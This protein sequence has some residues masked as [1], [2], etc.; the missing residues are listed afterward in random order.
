MEET[1]MMSMDDLMALVVEYYNIVINWLQT[2]LFTIESSTQLAIVG[3]L[4]LISYA[5]NRSLTPFLHKVFEEKPIYQ[6]IEKAAKEMYLPI[7][8]WLLVLI[9]LQVAE[10]L[11]MPII[12]LRLAWSLITL[13]IAINLITVMIESETISRIVRIVIWTG[14]ILNIFGLF[15]LNFCFS[16]VN[17]LF[18]MYE[19]HV[20]SIVTR[21]CNI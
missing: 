14:A 16:I 4:F 1:E 3:F 20:R 15:G 8:W 9:T 13:W 17:N 5:I 10:A 11:T 21:I 7:I 12:I 6:R 18:V 19:C 2:N